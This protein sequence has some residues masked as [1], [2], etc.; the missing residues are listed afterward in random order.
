MIHS[1]NGT[2]LSKTPADI[3]ISCGGVGFYVM[4]P[5]SAYAYLPEVGESGEVYT[6]LSVKDDGMDLYGF[7]T[8]QQ[9]ATFRLLTSV[10]GVGPKVGM[11]ILSV[12]DS[13]TIALAIASGDHKAFTA[14]AGVGPKLGQRIVLELKDKI[15]DLGGVDAAAISA[16]TVAVQGAAGE[17]VSA[18]VTLG[19]TQSEAAAAV[20]KLPQDSSV[21]EMIAAAL[22]SMGKR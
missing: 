21:E 15:G 6:H 2:V 20:A 7:A 18:L 22:R 13:D 19:F 5:S 4:I 11:A 1:L 9:R 8:E 3:V 16:A 12:L 10:S 17:A 14:A